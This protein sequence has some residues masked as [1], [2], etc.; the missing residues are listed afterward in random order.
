[1]FRNSLKIDNLQSI[2]SWR[3]T[4]QGWKIIASNLSAGNQDLAVNADAQMFLP[5]N[6]TKPRLDMLADFQVNNIANVKNYYPVQIL[7]KGLITWLDAAI[8]DGKSISGTMVIRHN[9]RI[10]VNSILHDIQ[11]K[12]DQ[13]WPAIEHI[14]G[15]MIFDN[16]TMRINANA[17]TLNMPM[18]NIYV[19]IPNLEKP[20]LTAIG[21]ISGDNKDALN[22]INMSSLQ[23]TVGEYFAQTPIAG[24]MM[25]NLKVSVP[26]ADEP[27]NIDTRGKIIEHQGMLKVPSWHINLTNITGN[28]YFHD[29]AIKATGLKATLFNGPITMDVNTLKSN[30]KYPI[31]RINGHG[32]ASVDAIKE[33]MYTPILAQLSGDFNYRARLSLYSNPQHVSNFN[34]VSNLEGVKI[35]LPPPLTKTKEQL[36]SL[37]VNTTFGGQEPMQVKLRCGENLSAALKFT[38]DKER[39]EFLNGAVNFGPGIAVFQDQP[40]LLITGYLP[41]INWADWRPYLTTQTT[42][43]QTSIRKVI[44]DIGQLDAYDQDL[45]NTKLQVIPRPN[46][47]QLYIDSSKINGQLTIPYTFPHQTLVG[48]F[49]RL[50]LTTKSKKFSSLQPEDVPPL[51]IISNDFRFAGKNY[52][53]MELNV[54]PKNDNLRINKLAFNTPLYN[55]SATG[56]W[57][58]IKG[59]PD[60]ALYGT[61]QIKD[62]GALLKNAYNTNNLIGGKG[63]ATFSLHWQNNVYQPNLSSMQGT[64]SLYLQQGR[65]VNLNK[66]TQEKIG[67]GQMLNILSLQ[68]LPQHLTLNFSDLT[69][70]G[71]YFNEMRGDYKLTNGNIY[72]YDTTL[73]GTVARITA[74]GRIGL[75]AKNCDLLLT[76]IPNVTSSLPVLATIVGGPVV[77]AVTFVGD[78]IFKHTLQPAMAYKYKITGPWKNPKV[79]RL[80]VQKGQQKKP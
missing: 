7:P 26:L 73:N 21:T 71:Y 32:Q 67:L 80:N 53:Y 16:K 20:I 12:F 19:R 75:I 70:K 8:V 33:Q 63:N 79:V 9:T 56:E 76:M 51:H 47:W 44:L 39:L 49:N 35:D 45:P 34:L 57:Q 48:K 28:I 74:Q 6:K 52:G 46:A 42:N 78:E 15:N 72:T 14:T 69:K 66:A 5:A 11:L 65:I 50:Y 36:Q 38:K 4:K 25:L 17:K 54:V 1:L 62:A 27:G 24:P 29:D 60:S 22:Y 77:G 13:N 31:T 2:F 3:H 10:L 59:K 30:T 68:A 37:Y 40:G 64:V 43:R 55:M 41:K 18:D 23:H 61:L 58:I